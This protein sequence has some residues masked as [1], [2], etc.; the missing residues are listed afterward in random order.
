[1]TNKFQ[2]EF[3]YNP[4]Q[5]GRQ[6][7]LMIRPLKNFNFVPVTTENDEDYRSVT[8]G[9]N[10]DV[11]NGVNIVNALQE[12]VRLLDE[13][14]VKLTTYVYAMAKNLELTVPA[15]VS[16]KGVMLVEELAKS[17]S[18]YK[19]ETNKFNGGTSVVFKD[20]SAYTQ[21]IEEKAKEIEYLKTL[22][23]NFGATDL[24]NEMYCIS[25]YTCESKK[26]SAFDIRK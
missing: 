6:D 18:D 13:K 2:V 14:G 16:Q 20:V 3:N 9:I 7:Q 10:S 17:S 5:N 11:A 23:V 4:T 1:M 24:R 19:A 21:F 26:T 22:G 12:S 25:N 8:V 15:T